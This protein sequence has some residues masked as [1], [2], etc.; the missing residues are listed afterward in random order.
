MHDSNKP[1]S[2]HSEPSGSTQDNFIIVQVGGG[3]CK[4]SPPMVTPTQLRQKIKATT[5]DTG[6][7]CDMMFC[8]SYLTP[9]KS[10]I[11]DTPTA[12]NDNNPFILEPTI[13]SAAKVQTDT[14]AT[15]EMGMP[16]MFINNVHV[17]NL[18]VVTEGDDTPRP[19]EK[20]AQKCGPS[21]APLNALSGMPSA[22]AT[23]KPGP[24]AGPVNTLSGTPSAP[25]T[26]KLVAPLDTLSG[27]PSPTIQKSG[28]SVPHLDTLSHVMPRPPGLSAVLDSMGFE[29][30]KSVQ[31]LISHIG[32]KFILV[33]TSTNCTI[34]SRLCIRPRPFHICC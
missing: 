23:Q 11:E 21:V 6:L 10:S 1:G 16:F 8:H 26:Q 34:V 28:C 14:S 18:I 31:I 22:P 20:A 29:P 5:R 3:C 19:S 15:I 13:P 12:D 17:I 7:V 33:W 32:V 24:L 30:T 2:T 27:T 9:T 25:T 4:P